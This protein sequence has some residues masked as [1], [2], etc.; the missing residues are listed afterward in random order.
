MRK[1]LFSKHSFG[2]GI[3]QSKPEKFYSH[4]K[5]FVV[6]STQ[7]IFSCKEQALPH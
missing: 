5:P 3:K 4:D 2:E 7:K 1:Y 6:K